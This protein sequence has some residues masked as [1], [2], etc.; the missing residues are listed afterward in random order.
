MP[1][2]Q[3]QDAP[4]APETQPA[5]VRKELDQENIDKVGTP[6]TAADAGPKQDS[7]FGA[8]EDD[9]TGESDMQVVTPPMNGPSNVTES[10]RGEDQSMD[11]DPQDEIVGG[12]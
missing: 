12:G 10:D 2:D 3:S 6:R 9:K 8:V 7:S 11:V 4:Q 5:H 1:E